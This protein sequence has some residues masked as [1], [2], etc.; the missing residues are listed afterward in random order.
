MFVAEVA[1]G[2]HGEGAAVFVAEPTGDGRDVNVAFD[3][4]GGEEVA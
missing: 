2:F 1:V 4:T 3:A